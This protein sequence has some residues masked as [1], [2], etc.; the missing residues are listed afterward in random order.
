MFK[1]CVNMR[2]ERGAEALYAY[3]ELVLIFFLEINIITL[4][5]KPRE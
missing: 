2:I 3:H 5:K 1:V 4:R